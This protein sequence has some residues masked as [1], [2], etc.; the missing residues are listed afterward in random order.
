MPAW[1]D[2][3]L[4]Q[5]VWFAA[6]LGAARGAAFAGP[7]AAIGYVAL[8]LASKTPA[9]RVLVL[10]GSGALLGFGVDGALRSAGWVHYAAAPGPTWLAPPWILGLWVAFALTFAGSLSWL[11]RRPLASVLLGAVGGPVAFWSG[12]RLGALSLNASTLWVLSGA[13]ALATPLLARVALRSS[14]AA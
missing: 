14:E 3:V 12:E 2:F 1:L 5:G 8:R 6:V 4:F 11:T 9:R 7:L 13:W 10:G